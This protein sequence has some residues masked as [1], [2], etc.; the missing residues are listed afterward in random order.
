M[1]S[2]NVGGVDRILRMTVG[3]VLIALAFVGPET[4]WGLIGIIPLV[5]G[6]FRICPLYSLVGINTCARK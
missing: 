6:L 5:T 1:F 3:L 4:P 2:I